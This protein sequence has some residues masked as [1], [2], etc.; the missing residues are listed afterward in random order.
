MPGNI[1]ASK[2]RSHFSAGAENGSVFFSVK[3]NGIGLSP[4]DAKQIFK[5][6]FQ[7]HQHIARG[8]ADAGWV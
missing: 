3:D 2:S 7:V 6:F 8:A 5:R 4:R 1:R